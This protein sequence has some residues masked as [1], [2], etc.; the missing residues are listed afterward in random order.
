M[1]KYSCPR[2]G[3]ETAQ[4]ALEDITRIIDNSLDQGNKM[5]AE[6]NEMADSS[7]KFNKLAFSEKW[8]NRFYKINFPNL[9]NIFKRFIFQD[10]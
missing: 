2:G 8:K 4:S 9:E 5:L 6:L 10:H 1:Q 7:G 3:L